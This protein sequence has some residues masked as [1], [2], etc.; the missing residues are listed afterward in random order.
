MLNQETDYNLETTI[1][2]LATLAGYTSYTRQSPCTLGPHAHCHLS[3]PRGGDAIRILDPD[4]IHDRGIMH[5]D[6]R[7]SNILFS[8]G[9]GAVFIDFGLSSET[10]DTDTFSGG[11]CWYIPPEFALTGQR[12]TAS[13][14]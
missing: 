13:D 12:D 1:R 7:P 4:H 11:S 10:W 2:A 6:V 3:H 9:R 14:V 8:R 5:N